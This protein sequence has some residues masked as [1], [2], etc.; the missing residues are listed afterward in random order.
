MNHKRP[1]GRLVL[2]GTGVTA[3]SHMTL[4]AIG[5]VKAAD[6]VFY[7]ATNG[8]AAAHLRQLNPDAIDLRGYYGE[9]K[10]RTTT[11][12][13]IAEV[14]LR[15]VRQGRHVVGVFPGHPGVLAM[16][17][18]RALA[19]AEMQGYETLLLPAVSSI[20]CLFADLRIDP[21]PRGVQILK[22]GLVLSEK[23]VIATSGHLILLQADAVGDNTFSFTGFKHT[24][25]ELFIERLIE[26]YG[27]EHEAVYYAA[28]D[29]PC[30]LPT[31]IA[32]PLEEYLEQVPW[33]TMVPGTLYLPPA[34]MTLR[35]VVAAESLNS[36]LP[37]G[38]SE[39]LAIAA[40]DNYQVPA[41]YEPLLASQDMLGIMAELGTNPEIA[42]MFR[43]SP[44]EYL[45]RWPG[46][47]D[48]ERERLLNRANG[49]GP[50]EPE[51]TGHAFPSGEPEAR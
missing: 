25:H 6:V 20:D 44:Q 2:V 31:I 28:A 21:G 46:L 14:M 47:A 41:A 1:A 49:T 16:A 18:R 24:Q 34:G 11:Y 29:F 38:Q 8:V 40:L 32:R 26:Q 3:V 39:R 19:I 37:Y 35:S 5:H 45:S 43:H 22:A 30:S 51:P 23:V 33:A 12:V 42:R 7:L 36:G 27:A 17:A 13:Q 48:D 15:Q 50:K 10:V 4:E 9:D